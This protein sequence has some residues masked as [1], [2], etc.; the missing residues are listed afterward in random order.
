MHFRRANRTSI[1]FVQWGFRRVKMATAGGQ[2]MPIHPSPEYSKNFPKNLTGGIACHT[3][4][5]L[6]HTGIVA[7]YAEGGR[8]MGK[9]YWDYLRMSGCCCGRAGRKAQITHW[10]QL[11]SELLCVS[12]ERRVLATPVSPCA[13]CATPR[14][15][16]SRTELRLLSAP[17]VT[18]ACLPPFRAAETPPPHCSSQQ[19]PGTAADPSCNPALFCVPNIDSPGRD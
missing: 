16:P 9:P 6:G 13:R 18:A 4:F 1:L 11:G 5:D 8:E 17:Q 15:A 7:R 2:C 12:G 3:A 19:S 14:S 10:Q